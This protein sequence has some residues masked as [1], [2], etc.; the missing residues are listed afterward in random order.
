VG[1]ARALVSEP[2]VVLADESTGGMDSATGA[3]LIELL[4]AA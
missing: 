3:E 1:V 4:M 2:D